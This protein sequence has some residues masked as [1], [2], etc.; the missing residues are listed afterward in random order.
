VL[1]D[2]GIEE[3]STYQVQNGLEKVRFSGT[4]GKKQFFFQ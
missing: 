4:S 1:P 3:K 2:P